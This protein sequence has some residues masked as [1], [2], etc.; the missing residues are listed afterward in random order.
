MNQHEH[1]QVFGFELSRRI[2]EHAFDAAAVVRFPAIGLALGKFALDKKLVERR[3][4]AGLLQLV[5]ALGKINLD[6]LFE[7][8]VHE[9]NMRRVLRRC[10]H[11][12]TSRPASLPGESSSEFGLRVNLHL[13]TQ[14]T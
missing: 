9:R 14:A 12:I 8:G 10:D 11:L 5:R 7:S 1:R 3:D 2:H 6:R 13:G 4:C